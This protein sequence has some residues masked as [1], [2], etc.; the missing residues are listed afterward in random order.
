MQ[1]PFFMSFISPG[2]GIEIPCKIR[3]DE[4]VFRTDNPE[5]IGMI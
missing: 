1:F 3:Y 4:K 5:M 2:S